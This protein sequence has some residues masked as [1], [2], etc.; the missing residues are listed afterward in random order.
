MGPRVLMVVVIVVAVFGTNKIIGGMRCLV[1]RSSIFFIRSVYFGK[2]FNYLANFL[3]TIP[4]QSQG[5]NANVCQIG[6]SKQTDGNKPKQHTRATN[7]SN[8]RST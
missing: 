6:H 7:R 4:F 3:Q 8:T 5:T 1:A 2:C